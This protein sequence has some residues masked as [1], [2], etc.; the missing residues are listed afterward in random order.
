[1]TIPST[2]TN[3]NGAFYTSNIPVNPSDGST[4]PG[5]AAAANVAQSV[6]SPATFNSN[7][8]ELTTQVYTSQLVA[9]QQNGTSF[10]NQTQ[11]TPGSAPNGPSVGNK[12]DVQTTPSAPSGSFTQQGT[13]YISRTTLIG[14]GCISNPVNLG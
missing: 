3:N 6:P 11:V 14:D 4:P 2:P 5:P 9:A 1:M 13:A 12:I 7:D 8:G 10:S